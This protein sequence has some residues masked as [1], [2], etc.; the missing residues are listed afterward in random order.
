ML[1]GPQL[2]AGHSQT[3][4]NTGLYFCETA[5]VDDVEATLRSLGQGEPQ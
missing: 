4:D 1:N 2:K 5:R 3:V